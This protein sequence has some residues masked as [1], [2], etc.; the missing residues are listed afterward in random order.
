VGLTGSGTITLAGVIG[1]IVPIGTA[2]AT[3]TFISG[4]GNSGCEFESQ[5]QLQNYSVALD[6]VALTVK[7]IEVGS[8]L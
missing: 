3:G 1:Q 7:M 4:Q 2:T 6:K 8:W 5:P